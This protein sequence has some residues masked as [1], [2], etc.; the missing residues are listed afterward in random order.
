MFNKI[1]SSIFIISIFF[2]SGC[3]RVEVEKSITSYKK[4]AHKIELGDSKE[5]VLSIL[6]PTQKNIPSHAKKE[7]EKYIKNN[8]LYEVF[9]VRSS[10]HADGLTTDDEFT[11]Y[12]F[13][14]NKLVAIGWS[15]LGGAKTQGQT[16][17]TVINN[18]H[19]TNNTVS[20]PVNNTYSSSSFAPKPLYQQSTRYGS[21]RP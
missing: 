8:N 15:Y 14:D 5:K 21:F 2:F 19:P 10:I 18:I 7:S 16:T 6:L 3:A 20:M 4:V 11:P 12:V 9:F 17:T 1:I 13:K